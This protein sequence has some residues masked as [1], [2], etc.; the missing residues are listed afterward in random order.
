MSTSYVIVGQQVAGLQFLKLV[1][2]YHLRPG[3]DDLVLLCHLIVELIRRCAIRYHHHVVDA[4]LGLVNG[5][6]VGMAVNLRVHHGKHGVGRLAQRPI[7]RLA[8]PVGYR[9]RL[10]LGATEHH[11]DNLLRLV[12]DNLR[13]DLLLRVDELRLNLRTIAQC[14]VAYQVDAVTI[15]ITALGNLHHRSIVD[16]LGHLRCLVDATLAAGYLVKHLFVHGADG[17]HRRHH[18]VL[19][20][21]DIEVGVGTHHRRVAAGADVVA[22]GHGVREGLAALCCVN[23]LVNRSLLCFSG[24]DGTD[25][26]T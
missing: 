1:L 16:V 4:R 10:V 7:D 21:T 8:S 2:G 11:I 6:V 25:S 3:L 5:R 23:K 24:T 15:G 9:L 19:H 20:R 14:H 12:G 22:D 18:N 13:Q 17:G 26:G